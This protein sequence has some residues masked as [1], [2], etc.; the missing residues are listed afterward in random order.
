MKKI[1]VIGSLNVDYVVRVDHI[2]VAG[3]TVL[4]KNFSMVPGGKGAN[5]AYALGRMGADVAMLGAVGRDARGEM[6][7]TS[8]A[9][10]GVQ[11]DHIRRTDTPTGMALI[12]VNAEG[13]NA[14]VVIQG[15][16]HDVTPEYIDE[17]VG[18]LREADIVMLQLEIPLE[19][20]VHAAKLAKRLGKT[21]ILDPAPMPESLPDALL[22]CVDYLKPNEIELAILTGAPDASGDVSEICSKVLACG[23]GCVLASLGSRGALVALPGV[24]RHFPGE[25]VSVVD[26]TA[27]GDSFTAAVAYALSRGREIL[28][29]VR[30]ANRVAAV[31]VQRQGA[32]SSIPSK[33]EV[34][35]L[36]EIDIETAQ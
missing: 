4:G 19:T 15:A 16:N 29:A 30:F 35:R 11:V 23:V 1:L 2:P 21:V 14:I 32:Q 28:D 26:T 36:W 25:R 3:E 18:M 12:P 22:R 8:L 33:A 5:Q 9:G 20:V 10:A 17:Q 6:E 27:A 24:T 13:D 31:V 34:E 7:L